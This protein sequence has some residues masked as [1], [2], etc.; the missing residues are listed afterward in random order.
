MGWIPG[1]ESGRSQRGARQALETLFKT[2]GVS[3]ASGNNVVVRN[4]PRSPYNPQEHQGALHQTALSAVFGGPVHTDG[5]IDDLIRQREIKMLGKDFEGGR[6]AIDVVTP[7]VAC[8]TLSNKGI[9]FQQILPWEILDVT[10]WLG[11][12]TK[13]IISRQA[14]M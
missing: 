10:R 6:G 13:A 2:F 4:C 1:I 14:T 11:L 5:G 12:E 7:V 9:R 3:P 8:N